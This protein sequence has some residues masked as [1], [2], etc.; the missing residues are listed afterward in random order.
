MK[1]NH[2]K[3]KTSIKIHIKRPLRIDYTLNDLYL[4]YYN[5]VASKESIQIAAAKALGPI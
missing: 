4:F 5:F 1:L 2:C 3:N